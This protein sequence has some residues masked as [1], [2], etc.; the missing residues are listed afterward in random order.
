MNSSHRRV[1]AENSIV[2]IPRVLDIQSRAASDAS[3]GSSSTFMARADS[4]QQL[5]DRHRGQSADRAAEI[6]RDV[7]VK[8]PAPE[9]TDE[10]ARQQHHRNRNQKSLPKRHRALAMSRTAI[11]TTAERRR[12]ESYQPFSITGSRPMRRA[13][14]RSRENTRSPASALNPFSNRSTSRPRSTTIGVFGSTPVV[15]ADTR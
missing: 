5:P 4:L 12:T 3:Q 11:V 10:E 9:Q 1:D 15:D 7:R 2:D 6:A 8:Q 13:S 14:C